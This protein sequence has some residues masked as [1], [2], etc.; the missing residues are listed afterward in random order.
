MKIAV[1]GMG[2]DFA[3]A[4]VVEG[5]AEALK[6]FPGVE[7]LLVGHE[8]KMAPF[9][10]AHKLLNHSMLQVVHAEEVVEMSDPS[11]ASIRGKKNSSIT[12]AATLVAEGKADAVV[13]AGHTGAAVAATKIKMKMLP[14]VDRPALATIMPATQGPFILLDA[15]ANI[16]CRPVHLAQFAVMGEV[17]AQMAFSTLRPR[18]GL[19]SVGEED[20]KGN[21]LTKEA[22]KIMSDMPINFI[23]NVEGNVLFEKAADVVVCDGFIGNVLLKASEGMARACMYWLKEA[24]TRNPIRKTGAILMKK[25][26]LELKEIGDSEE[27]G[28]ARLLGVNGVC[29]IGHGSSSPKAIKN[30]IRV[31]EESV[32]FGVNRQITKSIKEAG[33]AVE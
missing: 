3:P 5:V 27:Y 11:T 26:F 29:V 8:K 6:H 28:G 7:I 23:G 15:G 31:A 12:V 1:D 24:F 16:D 19:V 17:F 21:S 9:L 20:V 18:I 22:F 30:A 10:K 33:I 13:S 4:T 2:G 14:G 32:K 25:A